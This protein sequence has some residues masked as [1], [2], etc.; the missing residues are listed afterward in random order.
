MVSEIKHMEP[1]PAESLGKK[2]I[3]LQLT[4]S[5][6]IACTLIEALKAQR[7]YTQYPEGP[8][9]TVHSTPVRVRPVCLLYARCP[10][11]HLLELVKANRVA[12]LRD[13][14]HDVGASNILVGC[15][16][17]LCATV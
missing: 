15:A 16:P 9:S 14:C 3:H 6:N 7:P 8:A 4:A 5:R 13:T 10:A 1:I 11:C 12:L 17:V 2:R